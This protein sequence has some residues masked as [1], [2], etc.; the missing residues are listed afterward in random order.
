[1]RPLLK[2]IGYVTYLK[3][4]QP[5]MQI[6]LIAKKFN[7]KQVNGIKKFKKALLKQIQAADH[8]QPIS[9]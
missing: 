1:C 7:F 3:P 6:S 9:A 8:L 2:S 5:Q 4:R